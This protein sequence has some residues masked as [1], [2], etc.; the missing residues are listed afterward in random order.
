MKANQLLVRNKSRNSKKY[1]F[2]HKLEKE[3]NINNSQK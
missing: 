2:F 3:S 1:P